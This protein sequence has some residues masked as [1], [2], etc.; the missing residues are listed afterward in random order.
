MRPPPRFGSMCCF[1]LGLN[2]EPTTFWPMPIITVTVYRG[3]LIIWLQMKDIFRLRGKTQ[4]GSV[5]SGPT[6]LRPTVELR[7]R[8][9]RRRFRIKKQTGT[10]DPRSLGQLKNNGEDNL[11]PILLSCYC[12][13][14]CCCC[15]CWWWCYDG[16]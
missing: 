8:R 15:Y 7:L 6:L 4:F 10:I 3:G 12:C 9:R 1:R 16:G 13:C 11:A 14:C 5:Y 2:L